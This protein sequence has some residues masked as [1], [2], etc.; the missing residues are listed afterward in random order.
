MDGFINNVLK[1]PQHKIFAQYQ[2]GHCGNEYFVIGRNEDQLFAQCD[3]CGYCLKQLN[4]ACKSIVKTN[5]KE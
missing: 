2:C 1:F 4:C 3:A 5:V